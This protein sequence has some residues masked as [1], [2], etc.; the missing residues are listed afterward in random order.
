MQRG[1]AAV[2]SISAV[3]AGVVICAVS[4]SVLVLDRESTTLVSRNTTSSWLVVTWGAGF[5]AAEPSN[6]ACRSGEIQRLGRTL[7]LHGLWPQPSENQYCGVSL[8]LAERVRRGDEGLPTVPLTAGVRSEL[9]A[10]MADSATLVTHEWYAHGTCSGVR[11]DVYFGDAVTLT[12]AVRQVLDPVFRQ[13]SGGQLTLATVRRRVDDQLGAGTGQRVG[14]SCRRQIRTG[15]LVVDVRL[16]LP[17]V[18]A[19]RAAD[20]RLSLPALLRAAPPIHSPCQ[21]GR[22]A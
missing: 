20:G 2:L 11:A 1:D 22:V 19:M 10:T 13:A 15:T 21:Q 18:A 6:Q 3:L 17:P 9:S 5:C 12:H 8:M 16:S 7:I 14:L 4:F